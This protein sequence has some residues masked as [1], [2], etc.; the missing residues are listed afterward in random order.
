MG[1]MG[2]KAAVLYSGEAGLLGEG[3]DGPPRRGRLE[4]AGKGIFKCQCCG[5]EAFLQKPV[6]S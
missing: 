6:P 5:A 1:Y 2:W 3:K 4:P